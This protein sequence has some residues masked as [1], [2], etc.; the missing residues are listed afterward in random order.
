MCL[1]A[2]LKLAENGFSGTPEMY[3][4]LLSLEDKLSFNLA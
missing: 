4:F 2:M 1:A 3:S